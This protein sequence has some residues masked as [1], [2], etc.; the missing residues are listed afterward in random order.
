MV[1]RQRGKGEIRELSF[2][3]FAGGLKDLPS[4]V[5]RGGFK[6]TISQRIAQATLPTMIISFTIIVA[7][8]D[9]NTP[10]ERHDVT[11]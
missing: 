1:L 4:D 7:P 9:G 10:D 6:G 2:K 11:Q 8:N 3:G 5:H